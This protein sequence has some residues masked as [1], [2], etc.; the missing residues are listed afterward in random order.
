MFAVTVRRYVAPY[1]QYDECLLAEKTLVLAQSTECYARANERHARI[2]RG[3]FYSASTGDF[4]SVSFEQFS[5][6]STMD[7]GRQRIDR[8]AALTRPNECLHGSIRCASKK[9]QNDR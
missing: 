7:D 6:S 1:Q 3:F 2:W 4:L 9:R 5:A 8:N